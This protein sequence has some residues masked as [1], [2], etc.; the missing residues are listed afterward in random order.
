MRTVL[1]IV[2]LAAL[3][4]TAIAAASFGQDR[5]TA[6]VRQEVAVPTATSGLTIDQIYRRDRAGVVDIKV[7]LA[8]SGRSGERTEAE[9][10]G[11]VYDHQGD[12]VTAEHVVD[13]ASSIAVTFDG[14]RQ[15][16]GRVLG[17]DPSTDVAVIRVKAPASALHPAAFADSS[18]VQVGDRV[19]A[20]GSSFG[21]P[22]SVTAGI[23][24]AVGRSI[25][26][27][28]GS[29]ISGA[30]QTDAPINP[31]NSGGPLLDGGGDVIGLADQIATDNTT[32]TGEGSSS[33]V[34]FA[35]ASNTVAHTA[36][37]IIAAKHAKHG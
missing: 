1:L 29:T 7:I 31:G 30:I 9:G 15:V 16:G 12:I 19:V 13:G 6:V 8:S 32:A 2:V 27:P 26:A 22:E 34:G 25:P 5:G 35:V 4:G 10:T 24:S 14:G 20:I 18:G 21:L 23:V 17:A 36:D 11:V 33:G 3:A 28:N 37:E